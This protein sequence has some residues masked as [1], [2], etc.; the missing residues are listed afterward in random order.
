MK[1]TLGVERDSS[2]G[3]GSELPQT[4][5]VPLQTVIVES[6]QQTLGVWPLQHSCQPALSSYLGV[7]ITRNMMR[8]P[9]SVDPH[10]LGRQTTRPFTSGG[11]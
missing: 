1:F 5:A 2:Q 8:Q 4:I 9:T 10:L 7:G 3:H 6:G 11:E